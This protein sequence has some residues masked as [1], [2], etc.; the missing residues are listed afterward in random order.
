MH[1][2]PHGRAGEHR[3]RGPRLVP[4]FCP[5]RGRRRR[6]PPLRAVV[7]VASVLVIG[8]VIVPR[9]ADLLGDLGQELPPATRMLLVGSS[10][11]AHY[12]FL[13]IPAVAGVVALAVEVVR[14]PVSRLRIEETL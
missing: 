12:W 6:C 3:D 13:L 7:G 1:R 5:A 10:L 9:F 11:L 8:T 2:R 4:D 14:R